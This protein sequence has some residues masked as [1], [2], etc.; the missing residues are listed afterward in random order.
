MR[1]VCPACTAVLIG[2]EFEGIEIDHCMRCGGT[3]LDPGELE[4]IVLMA[5]ADGQ[6]ELLD[7]MAAPG[8]LPAGDRRCPRCGKRLKEVRLGPQL[9]DIAIDRCPRG[10]GLW[11]DQGELAA[12][13]AAAAGKGGAVARFLGKLFDYELHHP[14]EGA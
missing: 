10:D 6:E 3:W 5:G 11:L 8:D 9:G 13:T 7:A 12:L 1:N 4:Q 2:F 14:K